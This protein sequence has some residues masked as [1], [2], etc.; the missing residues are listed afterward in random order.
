MSYEKKSDLPETL[1]D[2]IPEPAQEI[3]IEAYAHA[4]DEY[5]EEMGGDA[6]QEAVAHR[7]AMHAVKREYV[8]DSETGRWHRKGQEPEEGWAEGLLEKIEEQVDKL[9]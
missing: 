1:R 6:G 7:N 4:Y 3:Y 2:T 9:L 8:H 5:E